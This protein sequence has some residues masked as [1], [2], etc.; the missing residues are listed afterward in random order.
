MRGVAVLGFLVAVAPITATP[1]AS[2]TLV[3]SRVATGGRRQGWWVILGTV[4]GLYLHAT[5]AAVGLAA[6]VLRSA[7]AFWIVKLLGAAYLVGLG[8]WMLFSAAR[9][10]PSTTSP[11]ARTR[12][13]P[14]RVDHPY[15]Q[16]LLG[17]VL[18]PKAAAIY[19]TLAP[20]FLEPGRP[21]LVP[22]LLLA[23][24]HSALHTCWLAG[25]TVVSGAAGRLLRT[26]AVRRVLDRLTGVIL[27]GLG[28]RAAVT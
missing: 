5:L 19:L 9:R 23:T 14:W 17:N 7:Q 27:L 20:Q 15:L 6:L 4:T 13:L 3:V 18:N 10:S 12:R 16:G 21:V 1:G 2:L 11:P 22:M 8:L 28:V 24:A 26:A 25:W